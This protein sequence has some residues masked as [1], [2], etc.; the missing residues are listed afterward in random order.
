MSDPRAHPAF[1]P[2]PD[3]VRRRDHSLRR[4]SNATRWSFA[5]AAAGTAVLGVAYLHLIP[6]T[7]TAPAAPA[8]AQTGQSASGWTCTTTTAPA[9]A[10]AAAR[11]VDDE[12]GT[13]GGGT[14]RAAPATTAQ[15]TT[16]CVAR[17]GGP[18]LRAP[19]QPPAATQQLPQTR[20]G[21]S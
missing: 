19:G 9:P 11:Q 10:P 2:D 3:A 21:A 5:A 12:S 20:T 17:S 13:N 15:T 7:S 14:A 1:E 4:A 8:P 16:T 18:G 6:G